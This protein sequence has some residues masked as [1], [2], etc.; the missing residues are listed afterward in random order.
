MTLV[1]AYC[2]GKH[3][4]SI[5]DTF[6]TPAEV[7]RADKNYGDKR[8]QGNLKSIVIDERRFISFA[9]G[10]KFAL[11]FIKVI[12]LLNDNAPDGIPTK[13]ILQILLNS[14][15]ELKLSNEAQKPDFIVG[16]ISDK[17]AWLHKIADNKIEENQQV[18]CIGSQDAFDVYHRRFHEQ[19]Q[20]RLAQNPDADQLYITRYAMRKAVSLVIDDEVESSVGGFA[21]PLHSNTKA[22]FQYTDGIEE[23]KLVLPTNP[24]LNQWNAL[25]LENAAEGGY[26]YQLMYPSQSGIAAVGIFIHQAKL[27]LIYCYPIIGNNELLRNCSQRHAM[28]W[29]KENLGFELVGTVWG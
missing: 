27:A 18:A 10:V 12:K 25:R 26:D 19:R 15:R 4:S 16:E 6:I 8:W 14:I 7:L 21:I 17:G 9:G 2:D 1:V 3:I 13:D 11:H 5:S 20:I 23:Y 28:Q 24:K 22:E 29:V